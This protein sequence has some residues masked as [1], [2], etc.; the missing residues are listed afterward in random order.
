M[1]G[2]EFCSRGAAGGVRQAPRNGAGP[3]PVGPVRVGVG[4]A[5]NG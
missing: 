1:N 3:D 4:A 5:T 2:S